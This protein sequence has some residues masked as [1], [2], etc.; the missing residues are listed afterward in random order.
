MNANVNLHFKV[1]PNDNILHRSA[2]WNSQPILSIPGLR[3][4]FSAQRFFEYSSNEQIKTL[5]NKITE[6]AKAQNLG[7]VIDKS[8][9]SFKSFLT[10]DTKIDEDYAAE[11]PSQ[12]IYLYR[13]A[14]FGLPRIVELQ[15][16]GFEVASWDT[17]AVQFE[18]F[19]PKH[20]WI[21]LEKNIYPI[22][23]PKP[24][25][26]EDLDLI[27][28]DLP[29]RNL[30]M[31]PNGLG[32]V[33]NAVKKTGI[34]HVVYDL[35]IVGYH[36]YHMDRIFNRGAEPVLPSG[37]VL[38]KDPWQAEHYDIWGDSEMSEFMY[39]MNS[40]LHFSLNEIL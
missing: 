31:M 25:F 12:I 17:L 23:I 8:L 28:L 39:P 27:L 32:Y 22:E 40:E 30:S 4:H 21:E 16:Q 2:Q 7:V 14:V 11:L 5:L 15:K 37:K 10:I 34:R 36:R 9:D 3:V 35:D 19:I 20:A 33:H 29:S 18:K 24:D 38:P 6:Y 1:R 26:P 13:D